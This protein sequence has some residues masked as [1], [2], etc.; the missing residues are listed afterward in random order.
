VTG[1]YAGARDEHVTAGDRPAERNTGLRAVLTVPRVY[2]TFQRAIGSPNVR[3][4]L[5]ERYLKPEPGQRVLD[6]GCGPADL[7]DWMPNVD[8]VGFDLSERYIASAREHFG[9]R[10][11]FFVGDV[12]A[13]DAAPLGRFDRV[14]AKGVLHHIDDA[15]AERLFTMAAGVLA[16]GGLLA[17]IDPCFSPGQTALSRLVVSRDR[18]QHVRTP[19]G[20]EALARTSFD[21]VSVERHDDLLRVPY[22]HCSL[23][24]RVPRPAPG[25]AVPG[26][27]AV[28]TVP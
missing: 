5:I 28:S 21:E 2:E 17:T 14:V 20:Y 9:D 16:P 19:D 27:G 13:V 10:G 23:V 18:G 25:P 6:I 8:Y 22:D 1:P 11:R 4:A 26:F 12:A 24:C 15:A 7:L 3:R